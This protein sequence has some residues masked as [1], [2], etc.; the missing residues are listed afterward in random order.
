MRHEREPAPFPARHPLPA[1]RPGGAGP[2]R[3]AGRDRRRAD[4]PPARH[5]SVASRSAIVLVIARLPQPDRAV[6]RSQPN[7]AAVLQL[8]G[9]Y[10]GTVKD[11]GLRWTNPFYAKRKVCL[12]VRNFESGKLKVNDIDG[13]PIEIAAVVV[14]QV[15]DTAEAVF[16]VDDYENF[17]HI[18]SESALRAD[19]AEL[20][21]RLAR[22]RPAVAAQPRRR[23]QHASARRDP[24]APRQG[25]RQGHRSAHQPPRLRA[26]NR[27]GDAAAPAGRRDHRG[28]HAHRR[29]RRQHGRDGAGRAA[30][31]AASS[32]S[33][34]SA[35]RRWSA[36]CSWCCAASARRSRSSTP[37][38][39]TEPHDAP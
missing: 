16:S 23:N 17:V 8:F 25:R 38:R 34:K 29:R 11:N 26:G 30:A 15:V 14:W 4:P 32:S 27:A 39:C 31:S 19:G 2:G 5:R 22:R 13:N 12:R 20:S 21:V 6:H 37:A 1:G 10:A 3:L 18:Q 35:R 33:T 7:Q 9:K 36:T 28:A 24:G